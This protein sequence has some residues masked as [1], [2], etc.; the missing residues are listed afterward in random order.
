MSG[1]AVATEARVLVEADRDIVAARQQGRVLAD[2]LGFP[3]IDLTL[4]ASAISEVAT[5]C[6]IIALR[7]CSRRIEASATSAV[8]G[9]RSSCETSATNRRF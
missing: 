8:T 7:P 2:R 6:V 5:V 4:I 1:E 9:V 3:S